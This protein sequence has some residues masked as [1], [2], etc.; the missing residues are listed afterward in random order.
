MSL[1]I[2][3]TAATC[4]VRLAASVSVSARLASSLSMAS[5]SRFSADSSFEH[6]VEYYQLDDARVR[7]SVILLSTA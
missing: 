1:T 4:A 6:I 2:D 7:A 3:Q 5:A